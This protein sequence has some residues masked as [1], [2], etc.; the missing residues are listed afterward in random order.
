[1]TSFTSYTF[2]VGGTVAYELP[3]P[4]RETP[5]PSIGE[6]CLAQWQGRG[7]FY[8]VLVKGRSKKGN[9]IVAYDDGDEASVHESAL[10]C[11]P[12]PTELG[13]IIRVQGEFFDVRLDNG[14]VL[15]N[16]SKQM[17]SNYI[18]FYWI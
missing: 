8:Q 15:Q 18:G 5:F 17:I 9:Y 4:P 6:V 7:R 12:P 16:I 10:R 14:E 1:M 2:T 3:S 13:D 11:A